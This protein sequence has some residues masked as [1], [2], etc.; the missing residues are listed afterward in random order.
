MELWTFQP[1]S[2]V[3]RSLR[4]YGRYVPNPAL[5]P[6]IGVDE[7]IG[8]EDEKDGVEM[9]RVFG[10]AYRWIRNE[11]DRRGIA[12]PAD[13]LTPVWA[14]ARWTTPQG[15]ARIRPD[16]RYA[17]FRECADDDLIRLDI[18]S[19]RVLLTDLADWHAVINRCPVPPADLPDERLDEWLEETERWTREQIAETWHRVVVDTSDLMGAA[20]AMV[21]ATFWEIRPKDVVEVQRGRRIGR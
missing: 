19:D 15:E 18:P 7:A 12:R 11:M 8:V 10:S 17:G 1:W 5:S 13:A 3:E 20:H 9:R 16:R 14:W 21:Q 2:A 4:E 6:Y